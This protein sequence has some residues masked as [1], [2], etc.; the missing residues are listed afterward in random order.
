ML[1]YTIHIV[2]GNF[3]DKTHTTSDGA[4]RLRFNAG[5]FH[6]AGQ[7]DNAREVQI[8]FQGFDQTA[9]QLLRQFILAGLDGGVIWPRVE[10]LRI[11]LRDFNGRMQ[12][13]SGEPCGGSGSKAVQLLNNFLS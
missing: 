12:P 7:A 8:V 2:V 10:R 3:H 6:A 5:L 11:D 9:G 13:N 1:C 4:I